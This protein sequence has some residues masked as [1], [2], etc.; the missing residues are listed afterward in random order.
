[1]VKST[2]LIFLVASRSVKL[3]ALRHKGTITATF[4]IPLGQTG[5]TLTIKW[6]AIAS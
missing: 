4:N 6:E 2:V 5:L 3:D 1:M